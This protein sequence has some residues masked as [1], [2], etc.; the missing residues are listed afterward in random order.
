MNLT[1]YLWA[2]KQQQM[3]LLPHCKFQQPQ[4]SL[5]VASTPKS[6]P[7]RSKRFISLGQSGGR[8][9]EITA[10]PNCFKGSKH[11]PKSV[12]MMRAPLQ[13]IGCPNDTPPPCTFSLSYNE[14]SYFLLTKQ[15][16]RSV[17]YC[18]SYNYLTW[19]DQIMTHRVNI[20]QPLICKS[21]NLHKWI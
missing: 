6:P 1:A 8:V 7:V 10:I 5:C 3:H 20:E 17:P 18:I 11:T 14:H 16:M 4:T 19:R 15:E 2:V 9:D 12:T 13:P 21:H